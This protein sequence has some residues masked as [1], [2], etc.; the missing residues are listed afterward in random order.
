MIIRLNSSAR[1]TGQA[2]VEFALTVLLF[3]LL[4]VTMIELGRIFYAYQAINHAARVAARY[5]VTGQRMAKYVNDPTGQSVSGADAGWDLTR[6]GPLWR[7]APCW[8]RFPDDPLAP[9][10]PNDLYYEPYR[11]ARVCSV[12]ETAVRQ[13]LTLPISPDVGRNAPNDPECPGISD[14]IYRDRCPGYYAIYVRSA[15][16][17]PPEA[18]T[19]TRGGY[20]GVPSETLSY[21]D[22]YQFVAPSRLGTHIAV[23]GF[24]G[25]PLEKV[26]VEIHFN[27]R[28]ITPVL[29]SIVPYLPLRASAIVT[30]ETFGSTSLQREAILPPELPPIPPLGALRPPD[31]V[32]NNISAAGTTTPELC[33]PVDIDVSVYNQGTLAS[34]SGYRLNLYAATSQLTEPVTP[35]DLASLELVG[36]T[37]LGEILNEQL[38]TTTVPISLCN[39]GTYWLYAYADADDDI[40]EDPFGD[41]PDNE[42][43]NVSVGIG[44]FIVEGAVID[45]SV[46]KS[47]DNSTP[48]VGDDVNYTITVNNPAG[49]D[50]TGVVIEDALPAGLTFRSNGT[51]P[52]CNESGGT[53]LCT[54]DIAAGSSTSVQIRARVNGSPGDRITNTVQDVRLPADFTDPDLDNN[55]AGV[56]IVVDGVDLFVIKDVEDLNGGDVLPGDTLN[57]TVTVRNRSANITATNV[58]AVDVLPAG[59]TLVPGST[60]CNESAAP[61]ITCNLGSLAPTAT[62]TF[63]IRATVDAGA[64]GNLVNTVVATANEPDVNSADNDDIAPVAVAAPPIADLAVAVTAKVNNVTYTPGR[65]VKEGDIIVYTVRV[66]NDLGPFDATNIS[67]TNAIVPPANAIFIDARTTRG[68]YSGGTWSIP[69][70][71]YSS[72][73]TLTLRYR[74][75]PGAADENLVFTSTIV[76]V[77]QDNPDTG[78]NNQSILSIFITPSA[79][80]RIT[81]SVSPDI[82]DIGIQVTYTIRVTNAGPSDATN[83]VVFDTGLRDAIDDGTFVGLSTSVSTGT[84][85]SDL[86]WNIPTLA[87]GATATLTV[88][89]TVAA[90]PADPFLVNEVQVAPGD[91]VDTQTSNNT[92]TALLQLGEPLEYF[93]NVGD[94]SRCALPTVTW[95]VN[96][97][98]VG[99]DY[100]WEANHVFAP[101]D[102]GYSGSNFKL[103]GKKTRIRYPDGDKVNLNTDPSTFWLFSCL[104]TGQSFTF[105]F[106][107]LPPGQYQLWLGFA[108]PSNKPGR[109]LF[110]VRARSGASSVTLLDNYDVSLNAGGQGR[111]IV[112]NMPVTVSSSRRIDIDFVGNQSGSKVKQALLNAIGIQYVGP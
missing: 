36:T 67:I 15:G 91:Q 38:I 41:T 73:A 58:V 52:E 23:T 27:H 24:A 103:S 2:L 62:A 77:D 46:E 47:V 34:G 106:D 53:V 88:T 98:M 49:A 48:T 20:G 28:L 84:I 18:S 82:A 76:D 110:D 7:I 26:I 60:S 51:S 80:L 86:E 93:V 9:T 22:Y 37:T 112:I 44:P 109:R 97:P 99:E 45:L 11:D 40:D 71:D 69:S 43:N 10:L 68:T 90:I 96:E 64:Q 66:N 25:R 6:Q 100:L 95:G 3:I 13:M 83:I 101:G 39:L 30:N 104:M 1:R 19:F 92:A 111:Y 65:I 72:S 8:P 79:D 54:V 75:L 42:T 102:W 17:L 21:N 70:L 63:T 4:I 59:I 32:V 31:L 81:K 55:V 87:Y 12:E 29:S 50:V 5:A 35:A 16:D 105:S 107:D 78:G 89:T 56:D 61:T 14:P 57:Y 74:V 85:D 108:D 94:P 33:E